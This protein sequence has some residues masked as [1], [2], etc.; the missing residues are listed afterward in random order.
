MTYMASKG[1]RLQSWRRYM[2][3][4][5]KAISDFIAAYTE[6]SPEA[7]SQIAKHCLL[8][9]EMHDLLTT[10]LVLPRVIFLETMD[11]LQALCRILPAF[12]GIDE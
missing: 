2:L 6:L 9:H 5:G 4:M 8:H 7:F 11:M 10:E 1:R 3:I 12:E